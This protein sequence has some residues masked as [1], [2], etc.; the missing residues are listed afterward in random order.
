MTRRT[1]AIFLSTRDFPQET[2]TAGNLVAGHSS[3]SLPAGLVRPRQG[4]PKAYTACVLQSVLLLSVEHAGRRS[5]REYRKAA[6]GQTRWWIIG[7]VCPT[8]P[9]RGLT[10]AHFRGLLACACCCRRGHSPPNR[11]VLR[12]CHL[13]EPLV[14]RRAPDADRYFRPGLRLVYRAQ[15]ELASGA[16]LGHPCSRVFAVGVAHVAR[17]YKKNQRSLSA[18]P[19]YTWRVSYHQS[20]CLPLTPG[21]RRDPQAGR[22]YDDNGGVQ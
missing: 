8:Q 4:L 22:T 12:A 14:C 19:Y 7:R 3:G 1:E 5:Q 18:R 16:R 10:W 17:Y 15:V 6:R 20:S 9:W 11:W 13:H 2:E 21:R